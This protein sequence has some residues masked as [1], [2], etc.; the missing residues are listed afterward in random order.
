MSSNIRYILP[1]PEF[2]SLAP[3]LSTPFASSIFLRS[4]KDPGTEGNRPFKDVV[5]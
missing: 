1:N 5:Q 4:K 2:N 3:F